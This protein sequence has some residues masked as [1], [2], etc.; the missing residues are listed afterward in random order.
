V[1]NLCTLGNLV[2]GNAT[3]ESISTTTLT[4]GSLFVTNGAITTMLTTGNL[5]INNNSQIDGN[6]L[7][8]NTG[9]FNNGINLNGLLTITS[10]SGNQIIAIRDSLDVIRFSIDTI[11]DI[12]SISR[13]SNTSSFINS[14]I[15]IIGTTGVILLNND[16]NILGSVTTENLNVST[17]GTLS[18]FLANINQLEITSTQ[19]SISSITGALTIA[20]GVGIAQDFYVGGNATISGDLIVNGSTTIV[21]SNNVAIGDNILV[22]NSGPSGSHDSGLLIQRY[23]NANDTGTGDV[24]NDSPVYTDTL[25][26]Q[27]GLSSSQIKF[28][29]NTSTTDNYYQNWWIKIITGFSTNQTRQITSYNG[30]SHIATLNSPFTNQNPSTGDTVSLYNKNFVGMI[31]N[32]TYNLFEFGSTVSD[33]GTT[34]VSLT[35]YLNLLANGLTLTSSVVSTNSTTGSIICYGGIGINS[36]IDSTSS[37]SGGALTINGGTSIAGTLQVGKAVYINNVNITPNINDIISPLS[38]NAI[39]AQND[40]SFLTINSTVLGYTIYVV[41]IISFNNSADNLYANFTLNGL[42]KGS[43]WEN[44]QQYIGDDTMIDFSISTDIVTGN[45]ILSYNTPDYGINL[46]S[47]LFK[48]RMITL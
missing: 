33:P 32:E 2:S 19:N 21:E 30:T 13:Y 9:T 3:L 29:N 44:D 25:G 23:Q 36:T 34:S 39:N 6:L 48:Y 14:P 26:S 4:T 5:F 47:I 46:S 41:I 35:N 40:A 18:A 43:N 45:G 12:F 16:T 7:V 11:N 15:Q 24:V 31:Y 37:T 38:F 28:S 1:Q 8:N 22:L 10:S 27:I 20:G 42:H 17:V